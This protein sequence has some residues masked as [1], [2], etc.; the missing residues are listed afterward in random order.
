MEQFGARK[1][2]GDGCKRLKYMADTRGFEPLT[3]TGQLIDSE[4]PSSRRSER[5]QPTCGAKI[6]HLLH[7]AWGRSRPYVLE[8]NKDWHAEVEA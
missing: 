8:L 1:N 5:E 3:S 2:E 4:R 7:V 6:G